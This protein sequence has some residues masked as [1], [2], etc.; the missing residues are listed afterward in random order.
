ML[1]ILWTTSMISEETGTNGTVKSTLL[2]VVTVLHLDSNNST[3]STCS[4]EPVKKAIP[5]SSSESKV[6]SS[7]LWFSGRRQGQPDVVQDGN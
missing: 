1:L 2:R 7:N 6:M 4:A 5:I 3:N